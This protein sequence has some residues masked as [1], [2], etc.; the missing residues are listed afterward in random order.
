MSKF[1]EVFL[2]ELPIPGEYVIC[3]ILGGDKMRIMN[4][5]N[6]SE[7]GVVR[8]IPELK[9]KNSELKKIGTHIIMKVY[10]VNEKTGLI[11]FKG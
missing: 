11:F 10:A 5:N 8:G 7:Y 4:R 9:F 6:Y 1:Y 2:N 3:E